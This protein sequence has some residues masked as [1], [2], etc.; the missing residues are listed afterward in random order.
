MGTI[1]EQEPGDMSGP[2]L[3]GIQELIDQDPNAHWDS[4]CKCVKDSAFGTSPRVF[5][6]PLYD[7][8]YYAD[9][10]ANGRYADF[11]IANFLGFFADHVAGNQIYGVITNVSGMVDRNAGPAPAGAFPRAI[12]LVQ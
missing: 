2:T 1:I 8:K 5:P 4:Y 6:I 7:P 12:R 10:Q 11:K 3:Q 9:G